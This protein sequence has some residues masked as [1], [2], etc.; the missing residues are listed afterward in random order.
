MYIS[1]KILSNDPGN[2]VSKEGLKRRTNLPA[3]FRD[4]CA[5]LGKE[6]AREGDVTAGW[7]VSTAGG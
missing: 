3:I 2:L 6:I 1:N 5:S 7:C 4:K